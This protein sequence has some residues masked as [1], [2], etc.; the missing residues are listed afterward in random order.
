MVSYHLP[1]PPPDGADALIRQRISGFCPSAQA[2]CPWRMLWAKRCNRCSGEQAMATWR[3]AK[4]KVLDQD[5][6]PTATRR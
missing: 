2:D 6:T 5:P 3:D 1:C 4:A